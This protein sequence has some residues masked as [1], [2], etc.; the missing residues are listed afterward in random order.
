MCLRAAP[1]AM[2]FL[3]AAAAQAQGWKPE[4][5]VEIVVGS[6]PGGALD[7]TGRLLLKVIQER[8]L[9]EQPAT[10]INKP[11][12]SGA[13]GLAYLAQHPGDGHYT[14]IIGQAL[15][16]NHIM[17]RSALDY[18][19]F[20]PLA[21]LNVEYVSLAVRADSPLRSAKDVI[22]RLKKDPGALSVAVG[23]GVGSATQTAFAHAMFVAGVDAKKLRQVT[24]GSGGESMAALLGGHVDATSSPVSSVIEQ[25]RAGRI[26]IV[27]VSAP[28][29]MPGDLAEVP[30]W[31]E[32]GVKSSVD[33]W[34][35]LAGPKGLSGAQI[36][37]WEGVA[38]R[39]VKD[40]EWMKELE[41]S[42]S[43]AGYKGSAETLKHW[44]S[45]YAEMKALYTALGL[46]KQ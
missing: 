10:V 25:M 36:A 3:A 11:G 32:L 4:R 17:G 18:T 40:R 29:R 44:Q 16:T 46:A 33:V 35:A 38:S 14:M 28:R 31:T 5:A 8:K 39:A 22:E 30:T 6:T 37:Y 12:G 2:L 19:D 9:V 41:R 24:F 26:R 7:R 13:L 1:A 21:I 45:E 23:T 43:E 42:V 20:T 27:A 15:L 34:R